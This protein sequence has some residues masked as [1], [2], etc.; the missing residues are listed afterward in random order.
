M[1]IVNLWPDARAVNKTGAWNGT[2]VRASDGVHWTYSLREDASNGTVTFGGTPSTGRVLVIM[3]DN[4]DSY[5]NG[6]ERA[7][8]LAMND[9]YVAALALEDGAKSI[10]LQSG[11]V[12]IL[13]VAVYESEAVWNQVRELYDSGVIPS[14][15]V[16]W[17]W[18]PA[19]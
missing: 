12:T 18:I 16:S 1:R 13:G 10:S 11:P 17:E 8:V 3:T 4:P 7:R 2:A 19:R 14:P 9:V 6:V 5:K 15:C